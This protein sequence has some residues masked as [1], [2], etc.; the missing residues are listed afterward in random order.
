MYA[1][2]SGLRVSVMWEKSAEFSH[3]EK[4]LVTLI[5]SADVGYDGAIRSLAAASGHL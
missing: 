4:L 3:F 5:T 2:I 1:A